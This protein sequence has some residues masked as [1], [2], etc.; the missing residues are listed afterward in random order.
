[1]STF[2][3]I[4]D[5]TDR[6]AWLAARAGEGRVSA[7]DAARI[8]TGGAGTWASLRKEKATGK[9]GFGGNRYTR[10]GNDRE[11]VIAAY[12]R[13]RFDLRPSTALIARTDSPA[14]ALD[15]ATPD[16]LGPISTAWL[17]T[18][19]PVTDMVKGTEYTV[20]EFGEYKT[21][22]HDW[23]T[24]D[25]VPKV[26]YWQ[27]VWQF[28][29]TGARRCRFIFEAHENFIPVHMEPRVFTIGRADVAD[30]IQVAIDQVNEWRTADT[31]EL[32][33]ALLPLDGLM[34]ARQRAKEAADAAATA[35]KD[36][37]AK[38]RDL[39]VGHGKPVK[40]E[41]SDANL[42]WTGKPQSSTRFDATAFKAADPDTYSKFTKTTE[43]QPRLTI[44][45]R[46]QS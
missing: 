28:H 2:E 13:D 42:S 23:A 33:E 46:S 41:G 43:S 30:D 22:V 15:L 35:L 18:A 36:A 11:A 39:L 21:T 6:T 14:D 7:T 37:D 8:M 10:H 27:V 5:G 40:F 31:D 4:D 26:Y 9:G 29:I 19:A 34:T 32:P 38:V 24:W 44:T 17:P 1:M 20:D 3:L 25:D 16:A 45:P 12:G